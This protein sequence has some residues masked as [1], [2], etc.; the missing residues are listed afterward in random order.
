M[1]KNNHTKLAAILA[2]RS[3]STRLYRKPFQKIINETIIEK[4]LFNL[5][6]ISKIDNIILAIS[7]RSENKIFVDFAKDFKLNYVQGN[8][9]NV[10]QRV[11]KAADHFKVDHILRITTDN[12]YTYLENFDEV[13]K[14]HIKMKY[15]LSTYYD[16]PDGVNFEI[17]KTCA[18]KKCLHKSNNFEEEH[19]TLY[20]H[21]NKDSFNINYIK[22][23][24]ELMK[25]KIRL[26]VDTNEDLKLMNIIY[27][28][29]IEEKQNINLK[30]IIV[31]LEKNPQL[32]NINQH[33]N[34]G[35]TRIC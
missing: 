35:S 19:V 4:I 21:R 30:N 16:L 18:L 23:K 25:K 34:S 2:C 28:G 3:N 9:N 17:I 1:L 26:T 11:L 5:R 20:M 7:D 31:F 8:E 24:N 12:P 22:P 15:D 14:S 10:L 6:K 33:L 27:K 32:L 29:L 13:F